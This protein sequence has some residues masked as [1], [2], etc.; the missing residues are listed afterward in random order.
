MLTELKAKFQWKRFIF[1]SG[2]MGATSVLI[3]AVLHPELVDAAGLLG[4]ASDV[5]GY[6][7]YCLNHPEW[8]VLLDIAAA[9]SENYPEE[10]DME[11]HSARLHADKLTMPIRYYHGEN[12]VVMPVSEML[13]LK[14]LL[15]DHPD[16]VFKV[17]PG[18]NH[19]SPIKYF[20]EIL[21]SL[22]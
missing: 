9:I 21:L 20:G 4:A 17:I 8:K 2:S 10:G 11:K 15:K 5:K 18:G 3:F 14:E 7:E 13:S 22:L 6:R 1:L 19:D 16:A 12:D